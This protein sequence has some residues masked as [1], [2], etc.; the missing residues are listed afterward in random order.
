V[1]KNDPQAAAK[2]SLAILD[3]NDQLTEVGQKAVDAIKEG[4]ATIEAVASKY[5]L[6]QKDRRYL[7]NL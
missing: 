2:K 3:E 1:W 4:K 6:T 5:I 7:A